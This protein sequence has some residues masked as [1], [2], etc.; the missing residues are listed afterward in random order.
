MGDLGA[1]AVRMASRR[2]DGRALGGRG[3]VPAGVVG[4][5]GFR[6]TEVIAVALAL[7]VAAAALVVAA[8]VGSEARLVAR[9]P[10]RRHGASDQCVSEAGVPVSQIALRLRLRLI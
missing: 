4:G 3:R 10:L 5:L 7:A 2:R 9:L 6:R 1:A 8:L